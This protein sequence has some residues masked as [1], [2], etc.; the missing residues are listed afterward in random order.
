[1]SKRII[2]LFVTT[3][4]LIISIPALCLAGGIDLNL[5]TGSA[6]VGDNVTVYG[7]ADPNTWVVIK[8]IDKSTNIVF[9]ETAP[10]DNKGNYELIFK[11]PSVPVGTLT[12]V[13]G[14][15]DKTIT[16]DLV[17]KAPKRKNQ[18]PEPSQ[19]DKINI[20]LT[21]GQKI[22][23]VNNKKKQLDTMPIIDANAGRTL[24]PLRFIGEAL[25]TEVEWVSATR[26]IVLTDTE[27]VIILWIDSHNTS[28]NGQTVQMDCPPRIMINDRTFV[29]LRFIS[30]VLGATVDWDEETQEI[31][32]TR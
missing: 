8:I 29:P 14:Y 7:T 27:K 16:K 22:V 2:L 15:G 26:Q 18:E 11:V 3:L 24:V 31:K 10:T 5:N 1:M 9:F 17:I 21:I 4:L 32:I 19:D 12:V 28:V 13:A 6:R 30:E 23:N 20:K 25:G